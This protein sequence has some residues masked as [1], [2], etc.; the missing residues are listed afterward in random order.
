MANALDWRTVMSDQDRDQDRD[1]KE[2]APLLVT[3]ERSYSSGN[4]AEDAE[5]ALS[6]GDAP[7]QE[8][9]STFYLFFLCLGLGGLQMAWATELS[10]G[11]PFLLSLGMPK[12]LLAVVWIA[13]PLSGVVVQPIVGSLSDNCKIA[14]GRRRPF[15]LA[16]GAATVISLLAL[17]WTPDIV[18]TALSGFYVQRSEDQIANIIIGVAVAWIYILDFSVNTRKFILVFAL[19]PV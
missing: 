2:D 8:T 12:S 3:Q 6:Y 13:G 17:A 5:N 1:P 14:W 4:A 9:K 19:D 15:I 11:S 7:E 10:Y 16:G 18:T